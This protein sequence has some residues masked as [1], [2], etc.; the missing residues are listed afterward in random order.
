LVK[1]NI[2]I[3][4]EN[5]SQACCFGGVKDLAGWHAK[6]PNAALF[7]NERKPTDIV[8]VK[9]I[10][11]HQFITADIGCHEF[12]SQALPAKTLSKVGLPQYEIP[13]LNAQQDI[14]TDARKRLGIGLVVNGNLIQIGGRDGGRQ[15]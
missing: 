2:D 1:A 11:Q 15:N 14:T 4:C 8:A 9:P 12:I 3:F 13:I 7:K 5:R 10:I 6:Q